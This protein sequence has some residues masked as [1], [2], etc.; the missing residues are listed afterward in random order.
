M[1]EL[2]PFI[3][4]SIKDGGQFV[5]SPRGVSMLPT[6]IPEKDSVVLVEPKDLKKRDI[7][8][9][10]RE[11]GVFV[12]HRIFDIKDG[13]Y[14]INGDNQLWY[15]E[16]TSERIIAKVEEIRKENG[17]IIKYKSFTSTPTNIKL[18]VRKQTR[19]VLSKIKRI[20]TGKK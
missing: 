7:I 8:L 13:K 2:L 15:E 5:F 12:L 4:E 3:L 1:K 20:I 18:F 6:I 16:T 19:R 10:T 9:F 14:I 17:K 11:N